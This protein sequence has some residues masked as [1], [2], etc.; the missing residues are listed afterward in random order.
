MIRLVV[1]SFGGHRFGLEA[2][3]V[4]GMG[5]MAQLPAERWQQVGLQAVLPDAPP[6]TPA[7]AAFWLQL[8]GAGP[9]H[10]LLLL[11]EDRAQLTELEA[12]HVWPLP[13]VLQQGRRHPCIKAL[14][15]HEDCPVLLLDAALLPIV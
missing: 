13:G 4:A 14:A 8:R 3:Q 1:F 2:G 9:S 11:L 5:H 7:G 12:R 10:R 6:L 15:W